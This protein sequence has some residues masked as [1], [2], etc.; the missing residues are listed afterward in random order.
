MATLHRSLAMPSTRKPKPLSL[1]AEARA[2]GVSVFRVR[3]ERG[4]ARGFGARAAVGHARPGEL[5]PSK[6]QAV[7]PA[8]PTTAGTVDL[9]TV[10]SNEASRTGTYLHDVG[11]LLAGDLAAADFGAKWRRRRRGIGEYLFEADPDRVLALFRDAPPPPGER[12]IY[13]L[14][15][16][17]AG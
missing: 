7:F 5:A 2:R 15:R 10:G 6:D 16:G 9:V 17:G 14:R 13:P 11:S 1:R 3:V 8:V 4:A 12:V